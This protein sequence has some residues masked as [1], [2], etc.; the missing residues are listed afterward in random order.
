MSESETETEAE[1][2]RPLPQ[3]TIAQLNMT[4]YGKNSP[5]C[6]LPVLGIDITRFKETRAQ[7]VQPR[8]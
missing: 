3:E 5:N 8:V 1:Y 2:D 7:K 4:F 6:W